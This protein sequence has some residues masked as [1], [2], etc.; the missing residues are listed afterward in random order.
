LESNKNSYKQIIKAT[1]LFGGVQFFNILISILKSKIIAV[2]L[3]TAGVGIIT[4]LNSTMNLLINITSFGLESSGI[5]YI[6]ETKGASKDNT[7][8]TFEVISV[9]KKLVFAS[10]V[11][12]AVI[13]LFFSSY[14]SQ[15]TFGNKDFIHTFIWLSLA[16][17]F[18]QLTSGYLVVL[19]SLRRLKVYA[20]VNLIGNAISL[21]I[22]VPMYFYWQINAIAPAIVMS[23][24][25]SFILAHF[26]S[27]KIIGNKKVTFIKALSDGKSM[28]FLGLALSLSG[29]IRGASEYLVQIGIGYLGNLNEVGLFGAGLVVLNSYVG[30]IFIVM[31]KDYYPKLSSIINSD[32]SIRDLVF[33]Q[34]FLSVLLIAVVIVVF[35]VVAPLLIGVLYTEA[36]NPIV[37]MVSWGIIGMLFKAV[38]WAYGYIIIAKGDSSVFVKTSLV[39]SVLYLFMLLSGYYIGGFLG[40][41]VSFCSYYILHFLGIIWVVKKRYGIT[42]DKEISATFIKCFLLCCL[43]LLLSYITVPVYKYVLMICVAFLSCIY[44][45]VLLNKKIPLKEIITMFQNE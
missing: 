17:L 20:K 15:V 35:I 11:F 9:F 6:S 43:V 10:G 2:L 41:G 29:I 28:I 22:V 13:T 36:F 33:R 30:V 26:W 31:S 42:I 19:Q 40:L 1:S 44:I 8:K 34:V 4:L 45:L 23:S 3:G 37:A 12:G 25:I 14:L 7:P 21:S 32:K 18:K 39:F 16:I 24:F 38:S 5:K 27:K